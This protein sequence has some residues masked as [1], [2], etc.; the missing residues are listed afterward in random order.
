M[1]SHDPGP[2]RKTEFTL[3]MVRSGRTWV[4]VNTILANILGARIIE[5]GLTG[6]PVLED[7]SVVRKEVVLENS[8]LDMLA[9]DGKR[10][11]YIEVKN[12]TFRDQHTALFPDAVTTRG[13]KHLDTLIGAVRNGNLAGNL[14]VVQRSDCR[15][16][17]PA[18]N[19]DPDYADTFLNAM[20]S[21]VLILPCLLH[22]EP[23]GIFFERPLP[24]EK[25]WR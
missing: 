18:R 24:L 10:I 2:G 7:F 25:T 22:V 16:F 20:K 15:S 9:G 4:G 11:C 3:E 21:G 8:R 13:K 5:S 6:D 14:F 23:E 19:I 12:V 17:A 1:L